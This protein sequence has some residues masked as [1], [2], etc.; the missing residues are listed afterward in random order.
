[1]MNLLHQIINKKKYMNVDFLKDVASKYFS[2]TKDRIFIEPF[3]LSFPKNLTYK[4]DTFYFVENFFCGY[5]LTLTTIP[6]VFHDPSYYV[7]KEAYFS[8]YSANGKTTPF[9]I[10]SI[11]VFSVP[12]SS[13]SQMPV[14]LFQLWG[15]KISKF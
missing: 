9:F 14:Q 10:R 13:T 1:M 6:F 12:Q 5:N 11:E 4:E 3:V 2:V 15:Y 7:S 8:N